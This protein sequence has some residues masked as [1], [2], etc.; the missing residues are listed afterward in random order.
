MGNR[1]P[2]DSAPPSSR[3]TAFSFSEI[4]RGL[5]SL[6]MAAVISKDYLG[7]PITSGQSEAGRS[8][9]VRQVLDLS[10]YFLIAGM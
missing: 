10:L 8:F 3:A 7:H 9:S 1:C 6:S 5:A 2:G 4:Q